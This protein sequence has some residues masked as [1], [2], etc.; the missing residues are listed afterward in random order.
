M[1]DDVGTFLNRSSG[2]VGHAT[3]VPALLFPGLFLGLDSSVHRH[4]AGSSRL[5]LS[6]EGTAHPSLRAG[7][8][9]IFLSVRHGIHAA[10]DLVRCGRPTYKEV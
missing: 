4:R 10:H 5:V 3:D 1:Q 9:P 6:L 8:D 2:V 7:A